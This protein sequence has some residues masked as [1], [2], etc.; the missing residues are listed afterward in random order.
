MRG[1]LQYTR[2][3]YVTGL[4]ILATMEGDLR[5]RLQSAY[6]D[7]VYRATPLRPGV[8]PDIGDELAD[9]VEALAARLEGGEK[10]YGD[11]TIAATIRD[12]ADDDATAIAEQIVYL[13]LDLDR[14]YRAVE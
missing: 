5:S 6:V 14:A 1:D 3:K 10:D 13:A 4:D 2:E 7:S 9:R 8:G 11:G 12:L